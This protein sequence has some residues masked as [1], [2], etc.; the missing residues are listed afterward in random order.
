MRLAVTFA[1]AIVALTSTR[2]VPQSRHDLTQALTSRFGLDETQRRVLD[3]GLDSAESL[4]SPARDGV[5]V[6]GGIWI[7]TPAETYLTWAADFAD[8]DRGSAVQAV[9]K[10]ST[11]P[12]L[13]DFDSLTLSKEDLRDL[14]RC[15]VRDC[16]LQLD[17]ASIGRIAAIDW[18]RRDADAQATAIVREMMFDLA[19][20]YTELGDAALPD[21]HDAGRRTDVAGHCASILDEEAAAGFTPPELLAYLRGVPSAPLPQSTSYLYWTTNS[22]GLKPTTRLNHT[23]VYRGTRPGAPG[24]VATKMLYASHYFHGGLEM[25]HVLNDASAPG[26]FLLIDVTRTRSDGLTGV[27]GAILGDTIRRRGLQS[28]RR[29]LRFTKNAVED[30]Y[31]YGN[32]AGL[33]DGR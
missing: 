31:R 5:A 10:L 8:F 11:P 3:A 1:A 9:R 23:V 30:R 33:G 20:R 24:I 25:R 19:T 18:R 26:R 13:S 17:A 22:F 6:I 4:V 12:R 21:Y 32:A 28:L 2:G 15:R 7:E 16:T 27:T 14:S 29:Y